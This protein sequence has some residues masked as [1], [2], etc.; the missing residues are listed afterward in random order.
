MS[1]ENE[2]SHEDTSKSGLFAK[3]SIKDYL[4]SARVRN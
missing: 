1:Y 2:T 4:L 3:K